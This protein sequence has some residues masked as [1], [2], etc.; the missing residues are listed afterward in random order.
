MD[1]KYELITDST[2]VTGVMVSSRRIE[3]VIRDLT[4]EKLDEMKKNIC[5]GQDCRFTDPRFCGGPRIR[6]GQNDVIEITVYNSDQVRSHIDIGNV[7]KPRCLL[8]E[9]LM[10]DEV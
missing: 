4:S 6:F 9:A 10:C 1:R 3:F 5:Y 2:D 8:Y 7:K